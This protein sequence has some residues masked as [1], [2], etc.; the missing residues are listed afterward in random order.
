MNQNFLKYFL[1]L[2]FACF[3]TI[4]FHGQTEEGIETV[5][6]AIDEGTKQEK[7]KTGKNWM[8]LPAISYDSDLGFQLGALATL[9]IYGDGSRY[10]RYDSKFYL[11]ASWFTK[12]SGIFRFYYDSETLIK[13]VRTFLDVSYIPDQTYHFYGYNG[14]ESVFNKSWADE[15]SDT[16]KTR[17]YYRHKRELFRFKLDFQ[18]N[19]IE[20]K[21]RWLAGLDFYSIANS[22]INRSKFNID[23]SVATLYDQYKNWNIIPE[24]EWSGGRFT[25]FKLGLVFDTRDNEP[26]PWRGVWTEIILASAPKFT[27]D[28]DRGFLKLAITHRQYFTLVKRHLTFAYRLAFQSTIAGYT[29]TYAQGLMYYS[30]MVGAYN[31]G[32]GGQRTMRGVRRNRVVGDGW[33]LGNLE[34][35]YR[36]ISFQLIKQNWY[37][38]LSVNFDSGRVIKFIEV[39]DIVENSTDPIEYPPGESE[40]DYFN[41]GGEGFHNAVGAGFYAVMNQTFVIAFNYGKPLDKQDGN[42]G[43]YVGLNYIF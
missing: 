39:K 34:F 28:M 15:D 36:F 18:G 3:I 35:R 9:T 19:I 20:P 1:I 37:L 42:T 24:S 7:V 8:G 4:S 26:N 25:V 29:P 23:D 43:F 31:E 27:S 13:G 40:S 6:E 5:E 22:T 11:E 12:G 10:P 30:V 21:F 33:V 16:Y 17:L 32:L 14:Y 41:F 2:L 38:A